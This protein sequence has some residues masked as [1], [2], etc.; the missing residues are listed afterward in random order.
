MPA[1]QARYW[2]ATISAT[3][4]VY[5]PCLIDP[6]CGIKGQ[7]ELGE[8]GHLHWQLVLWVSKKITR[9]GLLVLLPP[10]THVEPTRSAAAE[11]Y[12]FKDNTAIDGTRF[13]LGTKLL[14]RASSTDWAEV[15]RLA[16]TGQVEIIPPDIYVRY[17]GS[18]KRIEK[19]HL[20]P[21]PH[22]KENRI[23]WG[24]SGTGKTTLAW[25]EAGQ[26]AYPK[27]PCTKYWDGYCGEEHVIVD[28]FRGEINLSH[29]LR[30]TDKFP[31]NFE[32]KF[33]GI[34]SN[35]RRFWFTSNVNPTDWY[36]NANPESLRG[37]LRRFEI[38]HFER[39]EEQNQF[40]QRHNE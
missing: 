5:Y 15:R 24:D 11:E 8:G 38:R 3:N 31:C 34:C 39:G 1:P 18:L 17:Y 29:I 20:K 19:D 2:I 28:E 16:Q 7:L 4:N 6:I 12:V 14:N 32:N 26:N 10:G 27:D 13:I 30:W 21:Q 37:L 36:P 40:I 22:A 9:A 35:V 25:E 33:G 23:Y